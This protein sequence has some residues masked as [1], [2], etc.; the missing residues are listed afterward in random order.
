LAE[1]GAHLIICSPIPDSADYYAAMGYVKGNGPRLIH[2]HSPRIPQ[3][4][5]KRRA[6]GEKFGRDGVVIQDWLYPG[7]E[8]EEDESRTQA[9][10]LAQLQA[11]ERA[12]G[13]RVG[14][15]GVQIGKYVAAP[16]RRKRFADCAVY[17]FRYRAL[18]RVNAASAATWWRF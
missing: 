10:L 5:A 3:V 15:E 8:N 18:H 2:M 16:R 11:L 12:D 14:R 17:F 9:W 6:F 13:D 1:A 4:A 7:P